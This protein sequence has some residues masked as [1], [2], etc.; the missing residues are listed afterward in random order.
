[1]GEAVTEAGA[2]SAA[3]GFFRKEL[4]AYARVEHHTHT[5]AGM[6]STRTPSKARVTPVPLGYGL[7]GAVTSMGYLDKM[8]IS[9]Q[10]APYLRSGGSQWGAYSL[11]FMLSDPCTPFGCAEGDENAPSPPRLLVIERFS[12]GH[13]T[14]STTTA[15]RRPL[16]PSAMPEAG[17]RVRC[18]GGGRDEARAVPFSPLEATVA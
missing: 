2:T 5:V 16:Y 9:S 18:H 7:N 11:R 3:A 6:Q 1:M 15:P 8:G 17:D 10:D 14:P 12:A 13:G 4:G